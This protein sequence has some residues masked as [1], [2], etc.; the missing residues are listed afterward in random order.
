MPNCNEHQDCD[1]VC[2]VCGGDSCKSDSHCAWHWVHKRRQDMP[3]DIE[4]YR[5]ERAERMP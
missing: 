5:N 3:D 2:S 4:A 1:L